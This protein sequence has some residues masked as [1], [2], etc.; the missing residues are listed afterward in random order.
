MK[1][2]AACA[3]RAAA[4]RKYPYKDSCGTEDRLCSLSAASY[5][6]HAEVRPRRRREWWSRNIRA[7][8]PVQSLRRQC[9]SA[10]WGALRSPWCSDSRELPED[11]PSAFTSERLELRLKEPL[12]LAAIHVFLLHERLNLKRQL[13]LVLGIRPGERFFKEQFHSIEK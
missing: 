3:L 5:R 10:P 9:G 7:D 6:R 8:A 2:F 13:L 4:S 1:T 11:Q 12:S